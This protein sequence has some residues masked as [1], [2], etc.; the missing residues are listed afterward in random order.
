MKPLQ[1]YIKKKKNDRPCQGGEMNPQSGGGNDI[2]DCRFFKGLRWGM[3][4]GAKRGWGDYIFAAV[5]FGCSV[6]LIN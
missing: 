5:V 2:S 6:L 3:K 1:E 4:R